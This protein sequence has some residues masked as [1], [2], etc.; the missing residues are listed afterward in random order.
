MIKEQK[1]MTK[2]KKIL[3]NYLLKQYKQSLKQ[4]DIE[5]LRANVVKRLV[6]GGYN[7]AQAFQ[8]FDKHYEY[9]KRV[10]GNQGSFTPTKI[11]S[12]IS[13]LWDK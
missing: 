10:Y 6:S 11:A 8:K 2:E 5:A 4:E 1:I 9:I 12:L 3:L 7:K 13:A